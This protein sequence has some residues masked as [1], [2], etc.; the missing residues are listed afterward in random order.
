[1]EALWAQAP[2]AVDDADGLDTGRKLTGDDLA[3]FNNARQQ[4]QPPIGGAQPP[5]PPAQKD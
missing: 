5:P 3:R 4:Q 1:M 2:Q